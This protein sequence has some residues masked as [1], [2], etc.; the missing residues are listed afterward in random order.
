[1]IPSRAGKPVRR[2]VLDRFIKPD[3]NSFTNWEQ[4]VQ[5]LK[6]SVRQNLEWLLNTRR[7][8][9][10]PP[11]GYDELENSLYQYGLP[12]VTAMGLNSPKD[13]NRLLTVLDSSVKL[14]EPRLK[15]VRVT[16][17]TSNGTNRLLRFTIHGL[18]RIEPTPERISF[19]T[20]LQLNSGEYRVKENF[21]G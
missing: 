9:L 5:Q 8:P 2:S 13:R 10:K 3:E 15:D 4:S 11:A 1:M 19:D 17:D 18:L 14:F 7:N 12:D 6:E 21:G 20:V 16:L